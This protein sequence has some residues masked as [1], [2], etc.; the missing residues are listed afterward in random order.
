MNGGG[1]QDLLAK[2]IFYVSL[3]DGGDFFL[4]KKE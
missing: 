4:K 3:A 2:P 1:G